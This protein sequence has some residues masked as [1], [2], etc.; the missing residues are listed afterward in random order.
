ML[1]SV[2]VTVNEYSTGSAGAGRRGPQQGRRRLADADH[3]YES[4]DDDAGWTEPRYPGA[5]LAG[6]QAVGVETALRPGGGNGYSATVVSAPTAPH[7]TRHCSFPPTTF[8]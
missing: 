2:S 3:D 4:M 5:E 7:V 8:N 1:L 6:Y